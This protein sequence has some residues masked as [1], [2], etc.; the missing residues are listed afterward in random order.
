MQ[1]GPALEA[2]IRRDLSNAVQVEMDKAAFRGAGSGGE[3]AGVL[4]GSYGITS[5]PVSD[6]AEWSDFRS[7]VVRF[8]AANAA[9]GPGDVRLL[10]HP[11]TYDLM[12]A[13]LVENTAV[14]EWDRLTKNIPLSQIAMSSNALEDGSKALLSTSAGGIPPFWIATWASG[15]D[16]IADPYSDAQAGQLRITALA[17]MDVTVS[18]PAQLEILTGIVDS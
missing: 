8:M 1:A 16:L 7:A 11:E 12:D 6:Q 10:I 5:T 2:A 17:T 9:N 15:L 4:V 14:S 3:P 13:I 18:R